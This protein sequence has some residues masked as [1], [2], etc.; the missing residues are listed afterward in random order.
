VEKILLNI[1]FVLLIKREMSPITRVSFFLRCET[2]V[3]SVRLTSTC[4]HTVSKFSLHLT[5]YR[6]CSLVFKPTTI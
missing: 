2:C 6:S 3:I 1:C 4:A 5:Y